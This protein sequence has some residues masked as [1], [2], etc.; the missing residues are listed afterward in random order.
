MVKA[1]FGTDFQ[2]GVSTA[3]FQTEGAW[4]ADGKGPSIWDTFTRRKGKIKRG[5]RADVACDFYHRYQV[6]VAV[7]M[8]LHNLNIRF[9]L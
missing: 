7:V 8:Q 4:D 6:D 1:D 3:A 9:S 5:Y 2:W